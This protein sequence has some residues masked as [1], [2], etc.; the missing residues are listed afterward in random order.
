MNRIEI[1]QKLTEVLCDLK[2]SPLDDPL[3]I[4][5]AVANSLDLMRFFVKLEESF[6]IFIDEKHLADE[7][8]FDAAYVIRV[9]EE[10]LQESVT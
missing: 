5:E 4:K 3:R 8:M 2:G 10:C 7:K 9:I 6:D 1:E